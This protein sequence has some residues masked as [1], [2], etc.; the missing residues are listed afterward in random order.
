MASV[1]ITCIGLWNCY[2]RN[3]CQLSKNDSWRTLIADARVG[4]DLERYPQWKFAG[5]K[6]YPNNEFG[7]MV[8][9][10]NYERAAWFKV[11][12]SLTLE[13]PLGYGLVED[14]FKRMVKA[15]WPEASPNL[16]H[17]HSGWLDLILGI[18]FPGFICI[19]LALIITIR[20]SK[21]VL[22]PWKS[23]V[24][25]ALFANLVLWVSTEVAA[26]ASFSVL[27]FWIAL[28]CGLALKVQSEAQDKTS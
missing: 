19:L 3:L 17:S 14:S 12:T 21:T 20:Q 23:L 1:V 5:E 22:E 7:T 2:Q 9:I 6:G 11:G 15:K 24:F 13:R 27:L 25:W 8:S 26:T 18:G 28:S 4:F 10:T 16:S